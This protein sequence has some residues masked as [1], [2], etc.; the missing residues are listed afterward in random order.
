MLPESV[1]KRMIQTFGRL[2]AISTCRTE[3]AFHRAPSTVFG[4]GP[5]RKE[6][7]HPVR[8]ERYTGEGSTK[9]TI[10]NRPEGFRRHGPIC[11][12]D[13]PLQ[14]PRREKAIVEGNTLPL[15]FDEAKRL[16]PRP[17]PLGTKAGRPYKFRHCRST[18]KGTPRRKALKTKS[19]S[20]PGA[21][22]SRAGAR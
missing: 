9:M 21:E 19:T 4:P 3:G 14:G 15:G 2:L 13:L 22:R 17:G 6:S 18:K 8:L 10:S 5:G 20:D 7:S 12:L 16:R 11:C 1:F